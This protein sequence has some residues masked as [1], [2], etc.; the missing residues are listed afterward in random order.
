MGRL[1]MAKLGFFRGH[2]QCPRYLVL[3]LWNLA[4]PYVGDAL[5][6]EEVEQLVDAGVMVI[7]VRRPDEIPPPEHG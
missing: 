6:P 3:E 7:V 1:R 2:Q 5:D 4:R